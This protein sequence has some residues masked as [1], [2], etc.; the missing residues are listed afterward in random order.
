L[1]NS[2]TISG[3]YQPGGTVNYNLISGG[4]LG[5]PN[6]I[7]INTVSNGVVSPSPLQS[8][9]G[10][11]VF[12]WNIVY[13]G[14]NNN[15]PASSPCALLTV[16]KTNPTITT[17]LLHPA[18]A[19]D[20]SVY[21]SATLNGGFQA[22][23]SLAYKL[24]TDGGCSSASSIVSTVTVTIGIAPN[25]RQV[26]F[27]SSGTFGWRAAY[28]GDSNNNPIESACVSL[29]VNPWAPELRPAPSTGTIT[30][31]DYLAI[32]A[33]LSKATTN[34][35]GTV[36]YNLFANG[37]CGGT[38]TVIS[39]VPV[40]SG[41][42]QTSTKWQ[43]TSAGPYSWNAIYSG[44]LNNSPATSP[45]GPLPISKAVPTISATLS[46]N[47]I[48]KSSAVS[49]SATLSGGFRA[50]GTVTYDQFFS[51]DCTGQATVVST[52]TVSN[53]SVPSSSSQ[54]FATD[55]KFSWNAIY[56]GDPNNS[57]ATGQCRPL[58]VTAPPLLSVPPSPQPVNSGSPIR[59]TV[60]A[61]DPSWNNITLT[62]SGLPV[63]ASFPAAQSV[64]GST[65]S[66]FSWTPSDSQ[67][68]A[69]Y[70]VTFTVDDGHGGKTNSQVTIHV[71]GINR[72][73]PLSNA[74]PYFVVA[75]VAGTGF[76]LATPFLLRRF[77]K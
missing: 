26:V 2:A 54:T 52:V 24:F 19:V 69:D 41:I 39:T 68:L 23:G 31:G 10:I 30:V 40:T 55:G 62:V 45:C 71:T 9:N 49:S 3:G 44:D 25:S 59:F 57:P 46:A 65:S 56:S 77:R 12:G 37:N 63:G 67:A 18:I 53:N 58:T 7:A 21:G 16:L 15:N 4:C 38:S 47:P 75:L 20:D 42:A 5:T 34:A 61:T 64:T 14:D 73:S 35:G 72:S 33:I 29:T 66:T 70:K 43:F 27:N 22:G 17:S 32:S 60:T 36:T 51:A 13:S 6:T 11:G 1:T 74:I 50:G 8:F 28:S 76:V 48:S